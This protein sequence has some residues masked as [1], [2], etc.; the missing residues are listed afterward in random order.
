MFNVVN[1]KLSISSYTR[2]PNASKT[3]TSAA[4]FLIVQLFR[5]FFFLFL[6]LF[7]LFFF[8]LSNICLDAIEQAG[9]PFSSRNS[10]DDFYVVPGQS[11][12]RLQR[13][14]SSAGTTWTGVAGQIPMR[15]DG[16]RKT[17]IVAE[18]YLAVGSR[19]VA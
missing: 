8:T 19:L 15:Y 2:V 5:G 3:T 9:P 18:T 17:V 7:S 11:G 13:L 12:S 4:F 10:A 6:F 1:R 14:Q 16:G